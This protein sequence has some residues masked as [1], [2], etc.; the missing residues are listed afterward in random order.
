MRNTYFVKPRGVSFL[1]VIKNRVGVLE[2]ILGLEAHVLGLG[3]E[4]NKSSKMSRSRLEDSIIP[5]LVK[6][7]TAEQKAT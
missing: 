2:D 5:G 1:L 7:E 3:L 6:K 4:A